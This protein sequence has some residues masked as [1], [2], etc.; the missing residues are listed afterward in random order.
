[1]IDHK[2]MTSNNDQINEILIPC[3]KYDERIFRINISDDLLNDVE[4]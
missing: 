2:Y 1:M 4:I 3:K